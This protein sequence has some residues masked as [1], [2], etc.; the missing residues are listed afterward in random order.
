VS[1]AASTYPAVRADPVR[2]EASRAS[3][4]ALAAAALL[5][6]AA[7]GATSEERVMDE[8]AARCTSLLGAS[9][10]EAQDALQGGYPLGPLCAAEL[11]PLPDGDSCGA[12]TAEDEVCQVFYRWFSTDPGE[13]PGGACTCEL[14]LRRAD[15]E[16]RQDLA[17]ICGVR[18]VRGSFDSAAA[19][20][21]PGSGR[22]GE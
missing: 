17:G 11:A 12:A 18:F 1:F 20:G 7:C 19:A 21:Q 15:L 14:R 4:V 10:G 16:T 13:C 22:T 6:G 2:H 3:I 9:Y 8:R 5:A